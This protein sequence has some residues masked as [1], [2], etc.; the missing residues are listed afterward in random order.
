MESLKKE[1]IKAELMTARDEFHALVRSFSE[2]DLRRQS[3]N[4]GWTNGEILFHMTLGFLL[5]P[6]LVTIAQLWSRA[7]ARYSRAFAG[8]LNWSTPAF[9]VVNAI[10]PRG[11]GRVLSGGRLERLYDRQHRAILRKLTRLREEELQSGM[12]YPSRWDPLFEDYMTVEQLFAF[13]IAHF[14]FH[15]GQLAR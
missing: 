7:P 4:P 5:L 14:R 8:L 15:A 9:N 3:L 13:P 10:G 6:A 12:P 11:G 1:A 2:Q